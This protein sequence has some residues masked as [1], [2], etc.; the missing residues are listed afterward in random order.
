MFVRIVIYSHLVAIA[1]TGLA[2]YCDRH[3]YYDGIAW[4]AFYVGGLASLLIPVY[5]LILLGI[6]IAPRISHRDKTLAVVAESAAI[7][8]HFVAFMPMVQ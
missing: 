1:L 4:V 6:L 2:A 8:A 5:S 7:I 3:R